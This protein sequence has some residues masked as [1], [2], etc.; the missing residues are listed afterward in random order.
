[1]DHVAIDLGG[2]ESQI[3]IRGPDNQVLV[4]RRV[5]T[6]QLKPF[7][8]ELQ[9]S[10]VI[11]ET[12]AEAFAVAVD[13]KEAGHDVRVVPATLVRALGV[14]HRGIKTDVRDARCLSEASV[15]M[16][17]GSVHVPSA[18]ARELKAVCTLRDALVRSRTVLVNGVR[19]WMR[20]QLLRVGCG[21]TPTFT[22]RVRTYFDLLERE[23][24][25]YVE[26]QLLAIDALTEQILASDQELAFLA[27]ESQECRRVMTIPG[28]GP[29]TAVRFVAAIDEISRFKTAHE[30][31]S[32]FGLTP[33]ELSS[34][35]TKH[36]TGITKAGSAA[37]RWL[38]VQAAWA[39]WRTRPHDPMVLWA[40]ALFERKKSKVVAIAA[41]ARKIAGVMF[42][43]LRDGAAYDPLRASMA[44][45]PTDATVSASGKALTAIARAATPEVEPPTPRPAPTSLA[46][47]KPSHSPARAAPP[48]SAK[49]SKQR[50]SAGWDG[51]SDA[52]TASPKVTRSPR[53][54]RP[55][56]STR[57][58]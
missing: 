5:A 22:R 13:A 41:L 44:R 32:Y 55:G 36:R 14:G 57:S 31:E 48:R 28:V 39:A 54:R 50:S 29:A 58:D 47:T 23:L 12:C 43:L 40:R 18:H 56:A 45:L 53:A 8:L 9:P 20:G 2:R 7:F 42:A 30:L 27:K 26:R 33:G 46:S 24:P 3:C 51:K 34:S 19:G 4:E 25:P 16:D 6:S 11:L 49:P 1:M 10:R 15:R 37:V 17:L 35:D 52:L 38:V 21:S